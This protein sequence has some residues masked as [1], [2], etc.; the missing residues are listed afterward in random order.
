MAR[1]AEEG[2]EAE[3]DMSPSAAMAPDVSSTT[4]MESY[5]K[6]RNQHQLYT[7]GLLGVER[8]SQEYNEM[9]ESCTLPTGKLDVDALAQAVD[10]KICNMAMEAG[11]EE[12]EMLPESEAEADMPP[13]AAMAPAS[14][15]SS[16]AMAP[17]SSSSSAAMAPASSSSSA[18][19]A[20][21][22]SSS[23]TAMSS[24]SPTDRPDLRSLRSDLDERHRLLD[25][26]CRPEPRGP[27]Q[28]RL[29]NQNLALKRE[30]ADKDTTMA[31]LDE[32]QRLLDVNEVE[33]HKVDSFVLYCPIFEYFILL[34]Y[35]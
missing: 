22:S 4:A 25:I 26:R 9:K 10:D 16:A 18:A 23:S 12:G 27:E 6:L 20:P 15:S 13:S 1:E 32:I 11:R 31:R 34:Y 14:S 35:T 28:W 17:A 5:L 30:S 2:R 33:Y 21:A 7:G 19:M 24:G 8:A 3:G 29:W